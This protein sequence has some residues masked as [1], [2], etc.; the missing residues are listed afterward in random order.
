METLIISLGGSIIVP[1]KPDYF[2][3][4]EF[5]NFIIR[6]IEKYRFVIIC[7]GGKTSAYYNETALKVSEISDEEL[8][9][10]GI[11]GT[12]LNAELLRVIFGELAYESVITDPTKKIKTDKNIIFVS[13][14]KPGFSTD[15]VAVHAAEN[16]GV[17][18]VLNLSNIKYL[19]DKDPN[20]F[21]DAKKIFQMSWKDYRKMVGNK[22]TP[23]MNSPFD[24]IASKTA[25]NLRLEVV[26][27]RGTDLKNIEE[28]L[29]GRDFI[30]SIIK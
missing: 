22:W 25:E 24:P 20:K 7:G 8:D 30:G 17:K 3:L 10:L 23:R 9:R 2:F 13:G 12:R 19:Y 26:V 28:Y 1:D 16:F 4:R 5:K 15:N 21:D 29:S 14:W 27:L 6:N 18:R 11:A